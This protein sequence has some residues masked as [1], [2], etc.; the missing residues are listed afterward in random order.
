MSHLSFEYRTSLCTKVSNIPFSLKKKNFK[1]YGKSKNFD[2]NTIQNL[3]SSQNFI[4]KFERVKTI[5]GHAVLEEQGMSISCVEF[6][7]SNQYLI[8]GSDDKYP[9]FF[10]LYRLIK[11]WLLTNGSLQGVL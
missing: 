10:N 4:K 5:F 6:D 2:P 1:N 11:I 7:H 8:T 9:K 3:N